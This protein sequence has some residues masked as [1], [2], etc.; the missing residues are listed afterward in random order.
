MTMLS[1]QGLGVWQKS[2]NL[3]VK[4]YKITNSFPKHELY[5][6]TSQMRRA[7]ASIP[8]NLAEGY[9]RN[10]TKEYLQHIS[11]AYGS[12]CELETQLLLAKELGYALKE[13]IELLLKDASEVGRMLNGLKNSLKIKI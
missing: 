10:H 13:D 4:V 6:L 1:Y 7:S 8:S 5:G 9:G 2:F 3:T 12:L 11:I